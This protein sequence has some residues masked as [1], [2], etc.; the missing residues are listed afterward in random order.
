MT[1]LV[2]GVAGAAVGGAIGGTFL[3]MSAAG[4]GWTVGSTIGSLIGGGPTLPTQQGPRLNDLRVQ[5]SAYG[6][7]IPR[8]YGAMRVPGNMI[9]SL[10]I[11]ETLHVTESGGG[12][13]KGGGAPKQRQETYSYS[14]TFA[15][16]LCE[17]PIVGVRKIWANGELIYNV[18]Q[19][20]SVETLVA[21]TENAANITIYNGSETQLPNS[22]IQAD[23][24]AANCPAYRGIAYV[25]FED[26]QLADY[27]NRTPNLEFEVLAAGTAVSG[28]RTLYASGPVAGSGLIPKGVVS[29]GVLRTHDG[30]TNLGGQN[31]RINIS[32]FSLSG[33]YIGD[34]SF[35]HGHG[36]SYVSL[37]DPTF[38][39][40]YDN[41]NNVMRVYS[42]FESGD[43]IKVQSGVGGPS[44]Y[45]SWEFGALVFF[46]PINS[47]YGHIYTVVRGRKTGYLYSR[48][49]G[50]GQPTTTISRDG[51][52]YV[53]RY[54]NNTLTAYDAAL[55][56]LAVYNTALIPYYT[57]HSVATRIAVDE[58]V[59]VFYD[60]GGTDLLY[61][62]RMLP[63]LTFSEL[64]VVTLPRG[65]PSLDWHDGFIAMSGRYVA[66][67][68]Y[69]SVS[70]HPDMRSP[71]DVSVA[72]VV[73]DLCTRAGVTSYDTSA[74]TADTL[75][76]FLISRP[77]T[78]RSM[79]E[80][81]ASAF[82]FDGVEVDGVLKFAKRGGAVAATI[83]SADMGAHGYGEGATDPITLERVQDVEL[84]DEVLV[85]YI[86]QDAGYQIGSQYARRLIGSSRSQ[87]IIDLP[88]A[89]SAA[90]AKRIAD[91]LLYDAWQGRVS[92]D[93]STW[94][95]HSAIVPT[96]VV[97]VEKN[98]TQY[99][100]RITSRAEQGGKISFSAVLE[101]LQVYSQSAPAPSI[102]A[103]SSDIGI[104]GPTKWLLLDIPLLRDVD[105]GAVLYSVAR[106]VS[107]WTGAQLY[108][109]DDGAA[110]VSYGTAHLAAAAIGAAVDALGNFSQNTF[111]ELN[112]VTVNLIGGALSSISEL[113]VLN[114]GNAAIL[115]DE[116]LQFKNATLISGTQYKLTGLLR[117]RRG[118]E[119]ARSTHAI[120]ERFALLSPS[121]TLVQPASTADIGIVKRFR[122]VT[123]GTYI[124]DAETLALTYQGA[125][126]K[127]YAPV[128]L[129]GGRN[130]SGDV[131]INWVRRSRVGGAWSDYADVP[132]GEESESY[133]IE[134]WS[135]GYSTLKR[136]LTAS[137][138]TAT[139]TAAQQTA[140]F[141]G[142]QSTIYVRVYQLSAIV[143]RGYKLEGSL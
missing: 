139:Y 23:V 42:R 80:Q 111:D 108:K 104:D 122:A 52:L 20:A 5:S 48:L 97:S 69:S 93:F 118:T 57:T 37:N 121:N 88:M 78:A 12:G 70:F 67:C 132:I 6:A 16:A 29:G 11:K 19:G 15:I 125:S 60:Y 38:F 72:S 136:T 99:T 107:K 17:G 18:S 120:G 141:G 24:G 114:G 63:D 73:S 50:T 65:N 55:N 2:L 4:I 46:D 96:D 47:P 26:L 56:V 39:A 44:V 103:P 115:G 134:I 105:D 79:I 133:E 59:F 1:T 131:T 124:N 22:L 129:G 109:S 62:Y 86:D 36:D 34:D 116:I 94:V 113:E 130:A 8:I 43:A 58:D 14:Q 82:A 77:G 135:S 32:M 117:G 9:W 90:Q 30:T 89:L 68:V 64:A 100:A 13:G 3:G 61:A 95:K 102:P 35:T 87:T 81:L 51:A 110:W 76:G 28:Y 84:P 101:D 126:L 123:F 66:Q 128:L 41:V 119:W 33:Q 127:P 54:Y 31:R 75:R 53:H 138:P 40:T 112:S 45:G 25:V 74:L 137:T 106:G 49:D 10:P 98:G 143:G 71:A 7:P 85:N 92:F 21:S 27:G 142:T 91:I 140:D 83:Q